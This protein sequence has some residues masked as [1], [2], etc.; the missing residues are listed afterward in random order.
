MKH[1]P[2]EKINSYKST[3]RTWEIIGELTNLHKII[4]QEIDFSVQNKKLALYLILGGMIS[5]LIRSIH[6][7][8][9][10]E[11]E[12]HA[13]LQRLLAESMDLAIFFCETDGARQV[14]QWFNGRIIERQPGNSG[15]LSI[16][17]RANLLETEETTIENMDQTKRI[18]N[19]LLS[20]YVH[21]SYDLMI[22]TFDNETNTFR[23]YAQRQEKF[24]S[25]EMRIRI[26]LG[27][28]SVL[29]AFGMA[30]FTVFRLNTAEHLKNI[31]DLM[32][33]IYPEAYVG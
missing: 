29:T 2:L 31:A 10:G 17:E 15:N 32:R 4:G 24:S 6:A 33:E 18:A 23:Y 3:G 19:E 7:L 5:S 21:P 1:K 30:F 25:D 8:E 12:R 14:K 13:M 22:I 20:K 27:L 9:Y 16:T 28:Q 11:T 26:R